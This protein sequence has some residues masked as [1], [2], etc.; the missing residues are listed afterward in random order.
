[1]GF[2]DT[3]GHCCKFMA[4]PTFK[5]YSL[6]CCNIQVTYKSFFSCRV[7]EKNVGIYSTLVGCIHKFLWILSLILHMQNLC[8]YI[9]LFDLRLE[10]VIKRLRK[11]TLDHLLLL[12]KTI[13]IKRPCSVI[14]YHNKNHCIYKVLQCS[15]LF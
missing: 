13:I 11:S 14:V 2:V 1:M 8:R 7:Q 9:F 5:K 3:F 6:H 10:K 12:S 4:C 15:E